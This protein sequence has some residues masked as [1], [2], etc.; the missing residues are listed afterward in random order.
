MPWRVAIPG[1]AFAP[2]IVFI[3]CSGDGCK[4][5]DCDGEWLPRDC[6]GCGRSSVIGHGRRFRQAHDQTHDSIRIRRGICRQCRRTL[7]VLPRCCIPGPENINQRSSLL[8]RLFRFY[9]HDEMP[10]AP[11]RIRRTLLR[12]SPLGYGRGRVSVATDLKLKVPQRVIV[13]LSSGQ[14]SRFRS[15][16]RTAR[17]LALSL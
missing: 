17:D 7:T 8:R 3:P 15:S 13:P 14:V 10:H 5:G 2:V 12:R 1:H 4:P 9:F 16:F 11:Y 6:P